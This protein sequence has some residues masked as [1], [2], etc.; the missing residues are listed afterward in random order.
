MVKEKKGEIRQDRRDFFF[1]LKVF[2][3]ER[4]P[5]LNTHRGF[6]VGRLIVDSENTSTGYP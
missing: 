4:L 1:Q 3:V 2:R 5:P 6:Y